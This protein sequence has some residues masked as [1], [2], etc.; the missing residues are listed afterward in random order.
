[1]R[2]EGDIAGL[3]EETIRFATVAESM[4]GM[5][6]L[7]RH[8]LSEVQRL[9]E[10]DDELGPEL[11]VVVQGLETAAEAMIRASRFA[12]ARLDARLGR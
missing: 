1:M 12:S 6:H 4:L 7:N 8:L 5:L 2:N 9:A 10:R 11:T 3:V